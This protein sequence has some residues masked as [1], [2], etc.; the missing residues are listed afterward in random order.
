M[1]DT[2]LVGI[3]F[4]VANGELYGLGD[5]GGIYIIET[6]DAS[7]TKVSQLTIS[8]MGSAFGVDFNPA[9]DALR[10]I[11]DEGQ[12]LR[13]PFAGPTAGT[14]V[15]DG[16]LNY[17]GPPAVSP[18]LGVT[19]AGY[20]N[21]DT[22]SDTATTLYD[23]DSNL[24]QTVI[25]APPNA[26]TL[27]VVGKSGVNISPRNGFDVYSVVRDGYGPARGGVRRPE[28]E[29][30]LRLL[31]GQPGERPGDAHRWTPVQP[32][33]SG[34]PPEPDLTTRSAHQEGRRRCASPLHES[35]PF[36]AQAR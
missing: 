34:H 24:D 6:D 20:T 1:G 33:R 5:Q 14:T 17:V 11:S 30:R 28:G 36:A 4:R 18:A 10:I 25:Q 13:H 12:D 7:T 15:N 27:N 2:R 35:A 32:R 23:L 16:I 19:A 29:R 21:N 8:L 3:D 9:A 31:P 26:G 22:D